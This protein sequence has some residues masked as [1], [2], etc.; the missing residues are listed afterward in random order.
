MSKKAL[1]QELTAIE[2]FEREAQELALWA[3]R[4]RKGVVEK[5]RKAD[6]RKKIQLGG[7]VIAAGLGKTPYPKLKDVLA[8][9][10]GILDWEEAEKAK[11][12]AAPKAESAP[13]VDKDPVR[14]LW[15]KFVDAPSEEAKVPVKSRKFRYSGT[16]VSWTGRGREQEVRAELEAAGAG[17]FGY[18]MGR[19]T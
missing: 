13:N 16:T 2:Q 5:Q 19:L 8:E 15:V 6:T 18:S 7:T 12:A 14:D 10:K 1:Q 9:A 17:E 3:Q 4:R 11:L